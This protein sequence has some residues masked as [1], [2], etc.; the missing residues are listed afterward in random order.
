[1]KNTIFAILFLFLLGCSH[2]NPVHK[3]EIP[4]SSATEARIQ[5]LIVAEAKARQ[6]RDAAIKTSKDAVQAAFE[7]RQKRDAALELAGK[8]DSEAK[9]LDK[10]AKELKR[11]EV[12]SKISFYS[13]LTFGAGALAFGIG[14]FLFLKF[15]GK[16]ALTLLISGASVAVL[17]LIGVWIAPWWATIALVGAITLVSGVVLGLAYL[18]LKN[19]DALFQTVKKI[20]DIKEEKPELKEYLRKTLGDAHDESAKSIIG[21]I[22]DKIKSKLEQ[23]PST[24]PK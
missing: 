21:K 4:V 16:T 9:R 8:Y 15:G 2:R 13:W 10:V 11:Q 3:D 6:E 17:G 7:E 1:M 23:S 24:L 18:L 22:K 5:T 12:A 14:L 20:Q 19:H